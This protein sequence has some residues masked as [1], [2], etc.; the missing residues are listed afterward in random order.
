VPVTH[1][2]T[3]AV[4]VGTLPWPE[5]VQGPVC[6]PVGMA[7]SLFSPIKLGPYRLPNRVVMAPMTRNRAISGHVPNPLAVQYYSQRSSAGL[8]ITEATQVT[9][10]GIGYPNTP[11]I[12]SPEQIA[13]WKP[14]TEAVHGNNGHIFLQLWHVGRASHPLYQPNGELPVAP[15][16]IAP[17]GEIYTPEGMK[18]YETPRALETAEIPGI[19]D[20]YRRGA[21][22]ALA[23]GFDGVEIHGANGYLID[24]FLR[25]GTNQRTDDYGGSIEN[26]LRFLLEV[27][28]AAIDVWGADR[29]GVR[30][31]P[32]GAF[33][34]MKDSDS[35]K[36][37]SA[38]VSAL[39][40]LE[41][42]YVHFK[43]STQ[44]DVRHGG[45]ILPCG[46]F[47]PL[48]QG[49]LIANG[50]YSRDR[51]DA[52]IAAGEAD[53]IAFGKAFLANPDL[54]RRLQLGL[55]L[56]TPDTATFYG[57]TEKGYTD[58]PASTIS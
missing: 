56:N 44:D 11:G 4:V 9:P 36:T 55:E 8:L 16:A 38:A 13:G 12:H 15:S 45:E 5:A 24:Q 19:V 29:V 49:A 50:D 52:L 53:L 32:G 43:E 57:G 26:R 20:D 23:A 28:Q 1:L 14:V 58:Y 22:N 30:L 10:R 33:N 21:Q 39:D 7:K 41:I 51:A 6:Y 48:F 42:A 35:T 18:P 37:F 27:T 40:A 3:I 47:R 34:D 25:D 17:K 54:P 31:S 46:L 2:K